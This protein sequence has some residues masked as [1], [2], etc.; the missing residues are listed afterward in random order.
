LVKLK[1]YKNGIEQMKCEKIP[2]LDIP[3]GWKNLINWPTIFDLN[4]MLVD[5]IP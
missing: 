2:S 1:L 4:L 5:S 3:I